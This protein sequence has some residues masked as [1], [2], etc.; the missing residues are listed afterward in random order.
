MTESND[1][2]ETIMLYCVRASFSAYTKWFFLQF[3]A[4]MM[5]KSAVD[6]TKKYC[7]T[8]AP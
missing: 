2:L 7:N 3:R 5:S 4:L 6:N 1:S 8:A